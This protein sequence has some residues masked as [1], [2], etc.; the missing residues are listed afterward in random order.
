[1]IE[2]NL[3]PE[4]L[5]KRK[6]KF[7]MPE[8][9]VISIAVVFI[10]FLVA[11]QLILSGWILM[12]KGQLVALDAKWEALAPAKAELDSI[13]KTLLD[14]GRKTNAIEALIAE[15]LSWA[16]LLDE[17]SNSLSANIWLTEL[18]YRSGQAGPSGR[19]SSAGSFEEDLTLSG[20]AAARGE[21]AT[22]DIARFIKALKANKNFFKYFDDI[23]LV[24]IREGL[25]ADKELM[26]FTLVCKFKTGK[27]LN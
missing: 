1:M 19:P 17:L 10:G 27:E 5:R 7:E 3:L 21:Q 22:Q 16:R 18:A 13:K 6:K 11:V 23:E 2:L 12:S 20:S 8:I 24:S 15:R 9:P 4:E 14:T 26:D 25:H